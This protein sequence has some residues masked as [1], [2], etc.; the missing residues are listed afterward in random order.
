MFCDRIKTPVDNVLELR[1]HS[2]PASTARESHPCETGVEL[3]SHKLEPITLRV[4]VR[5]EIVDELVETSGV[6]CER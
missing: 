2:E 6:C 4:V 5:D 1:C 3:G